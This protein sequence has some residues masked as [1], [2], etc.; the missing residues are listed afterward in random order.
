MG[1]KRAMRPRAPQGLGRFALFHNN[2]D[3]TF[4]DVS[5]SCV[6][7]PNAYFGWG[8]LGGHFN[9]TGGLISTWLMIPPP[10]ICTANEGN[11]KFTEIGMESG[12]ALGEDGHEQAGMGVS[13]GD[14]L[15]TGRPSLVVT[16]LRAG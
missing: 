9:N 15:H 5:K 16:K 11:G 7:D 1:I 8:P 14:Y 13:T 2:G 6:D 4:S 3:G 12:T 10:V